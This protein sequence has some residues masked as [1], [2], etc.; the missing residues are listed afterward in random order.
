[1]TGHNEKEKK[2]RGGV[3]SAEKE[4]GRG[5]IRFVVD[6][7]WS[8]RLLR[9]LG[10]FVLAYLFTRSEMLFGAHPLGLA[11]LAAA[12]S[13]LFWIYAGLLVSVIPSFGMKALIYAVVY[14]AMILL[15][16]AIRMTVDLPKEESGVEVRSF[17]DF[18]RTLFREQTALRVMTACVGAFLIGLYGMVAGGYQ[19]YDLYHALFLMVS[20]PVLV[21]FLSGLWAENVTALLHLRD[22]FSL[23]VTG[24]CLTYAL[25][26]MQSYGISLSVF[27]AL[28]FTL[29]MTLRRGAAV[30]IL[31]GLFT[32]LFVGPI[33]APLFG[34]AALA[35]AL[36]RRMSVFGASLLAMSVGSAWGLYVYGLSALSRLFP[37]LIAGAMVFCM[38]ER[39]GFLPGGEGEA[40]AEGK[41]SNVTAEEV[42]ASPPNTGRL[43]LEEGGEE[44]V[45]AAERLRREQ[46]KV[47]DLCGAFLSVSELLKSLKESGKY[48]SVDELRRVCDRVCDEFCP[49]CVSCSRCWGS[50]Y[51]EMADLLGRMAEELRKTGRLEEVILP[52]GLRER[53]ERYGAIL[54]R[55]NEEAGILAASAMRREKAGML[56]SDYSAAADLF[57]A[58]A[59]SPPEEYTADAEKGAAGRSF[60]EE[61]GIYPARITVSG[62]RS[63]L[64]ILRGVEERAVRRLLGRGADRAAFRSVF[65]FVPSEPCFSEI[66]NGGGLTDVRISAAVQYRV[67]SAHLSRSARAAGREEGTCGDAVSLFESG[68]GRSFALLSDG[69][70]SGGDAARLSGICTMFLSRLLSA[71]GDTDVTLRMLNDFLIAGAMGETSAT[72]DLLEMDLFSGEAGFYKSGAAPSYILREGNVFRLTS[73]TVPAGILPEVD[74]QKSVFRLYHGDVI[75]MLSDGVYDGVTETGEDCVFLETMLGGIEHEEDLRAAA[76]RIVNAAIQKGADRADD[77]T[78]VLL[79]VTECEREAETPREVRAAG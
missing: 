1:M 18:S 8:I 74:V 5:R 12:E 65:G 6:R 22:I 23:T 63:G 36:V 52:E 10:L 66:P 41:G 38:L 54:L 56:S 47:E 57:R 21:F 46:K 43:L 79:R 29:W 7:E 49:G 26:G 39:L 25:L 75:V 14:T 11:L 19:F 77:R 33:T 60:F 69:M 51:A 78:V 42:R 27:F 70:G 2:G 16:V 13:G 58:A 24:A 53:C 71:G 73:R 37:A 40:I 67:S 50:E 15:R 9:G 32:G 64:L 72:I 20:A 28:V 55:I 48:P 59:S 44:A 30:G 4:R 34:F 31:V 45:L 76:E 35:F 61:R 68:E 17:S 62:G 3:D